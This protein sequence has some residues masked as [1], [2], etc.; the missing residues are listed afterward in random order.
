[1]TLV[2]LTDLLKELEGEHFDN[3][4]ALEEA[5]VKVFNEHVADL[6]IGYSY[7]D[8]IEG[9]RTE[10]WLETNGDGHGVTVRLG[11]ARPMLAH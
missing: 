1:M 10:G 2:T 8:A 5:V 3:R 7:K 4:R 11:D 9:A 6:P